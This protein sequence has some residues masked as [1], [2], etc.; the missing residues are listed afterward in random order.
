M[1]GLELRSSDKVPA[2]VEEGVRVHVEE[3]EEHQFIGETVEL[4]QVLLSRESADV[5]LKSGCQQKTL[6]QVVMRF[7]SGCRRK[8]IEENFTGPSSLISILNLLD[9]YCFLKG[10]II[11]GRRRIVW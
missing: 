4:G 3:D 6:I 9:R 11:S 5:S 2:K 7:K 10:L 8:I 1:R